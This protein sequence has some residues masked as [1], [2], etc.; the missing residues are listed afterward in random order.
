MPGT[1]RC[2]GELSFGWVGDCDIPFVDPTRLIERDP[3]PITV[4][5]CD[6]KLMSLVDG[7]NIAVVDF[8]DR[9]LPD[10]NAVAH[11]L[12]MGR[13]DHHTSQ[14]ENSGENSGLLKKPPTRPH[15]DC[16]PSQLI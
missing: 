5:M 8:Q 11:R 7:C 16:R 4:D 9:V 14:E 1:N 2:V 10:H 3:K 13:Q 6:F 15:S 12:C